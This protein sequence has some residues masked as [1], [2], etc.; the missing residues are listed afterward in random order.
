MAAPARSLTDLTYRPGAANTATA[1]TN[2]T[3]NLAAA[4]PL[5]TTPQDANLLPPD[6]TATDWSRGYLQG[7]LHGMNLG[8]CQ[9]QPL[10]PITAAYGA[11]PPPAPAYPGMAPAAPV[12]PGVAAVAPAP[13]FAV[14]AP[15]SDQLNSETESN[16]DTALTLACAGGHEELVQLLIKRGAAIGEWGGGI[17]GR[18]S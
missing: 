10:S 17:G 6:Q 9:P 12:A 13:A 1:N 16:H 15:A 11:T 18:R 2:T 5:D 4:V 3:T 14:P 8:L 7:T